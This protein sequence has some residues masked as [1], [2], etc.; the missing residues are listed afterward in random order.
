[1]SVAFKT[2]SLGAIQTQIMLIDPY[3][4]PHGPGQIRP[5]PI[6]MQTYS[7]IRSA[8]INTP[9]G[10]NM[11]QEVPARVYDPTIAATNTANIATIKQLE[12]DKAKLNATAK[13]S[14]IANQAAIAKIKIA[15]NS[16]QLNLNA[17]I[18]KLASEVDTT[19]N[20]LENKNR[21]LANIN[22][23]Y[24]AKYE[25]YKILQDNYSAMRGSYQQVKAVSD[26]R[27]NEIKK[28]EIENKNTNNEIQRMETNIGV[29]AKNHANLLLSSN[30]K[31]ATLQNE[32]TTAN[33][34]LV[35]LEKI[36][37]DL[38][39][40]N[41]SVDVQLVETVKDYTSQIYLIG[42]ELE[43]AQI[44]RRDQG[45]VLQSEKDALKLEKDQI[46]II[47]QD[48]Q[49]IINQQ[50]VEL[51]SI[52]V[53]L[54]NLR[55]RYDKNIQEQQTIAKQAQDIKV[56]NTILLQE[57]QQQENELKTLEQR[58]TQIVQ[59]KIANAEEQEK[60]FIA[61]ENE[62]IN[63]NAENQAKWNIANEQMQNEIEGFK[64]QIAKAKEGVPSDPSISVPDP[65]G[66]SAPIS[67]TGQ[68]EQIIITSPWKN[69]FPWL[70]ILGTI[71]AEQL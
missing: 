66:G 67:Q 47:S 15:N 52:N 60:R 43:Q 3:N 6:G 36:K 63:K 9:G 7:S 54:H 35:T 4:L 40:K 59:E 70:L 41:Q 11:Q 14:T 24:L 68:P 39:V 48:R 1:M 8:S 71:A 38:I 58:T 28:L 55:I 42:K 57:K 37:T 69:I 50:K 62:L 20:T 2:N 29:V 34:Q 23:Q 16:L 17:T 26:N 64:Q 46:S 27:A 10:F 31:I 61:L 25:Q 49:F 21:S 65:S 5:R 30:Q 32:L 22:A 45:N 12:I 19:L 13:S 33:K 44:D 18:K 53:T 56:K 51:G